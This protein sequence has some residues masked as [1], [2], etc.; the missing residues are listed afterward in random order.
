MERRNLLADLPADRSREAF[1]ALLETPALR[2]ER[3]VSYGQ[4]TPPGQWYDQPTDEWV[5]LLSGSAMLHFEGEPEPML[6][7]PGDCVLIPAHARHRVERTDAAQATV[8]VALHG[9]LGSA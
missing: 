8:W 5:L 6:L 3:I 4:A 9:R 1:E 7:Q 2:L